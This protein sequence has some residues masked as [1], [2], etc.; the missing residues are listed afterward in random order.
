MPLWNRMRGRSSSID[1]AQDTLLRKRVKRLALISLALTCS[2]FVIY[3]IFALAYSAFIYMADV[4]QIER[5][6][7]R[8][9]LAIIAGSLFFQTVVVWSCVF[10]RRLSLMV[11][12]G[13]SLGAILLLISWWYPRQTVV[14][15]TTRVV[16][17]YV[18]LFTVLV[19]LVS[20]AGVAMARRH[21]LRIER[22]RSAR[23]CTKCGYSLNGLSLGRPCPECGYI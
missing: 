16:L 21:E 23:C 7:S 4:S 3:T 17:L 9:F 8:N 10:A 6:A 12:A 18:T 5:S 1:L 20:V 14:G 11:V 2:V 19:E 15:S 13:C 22:L